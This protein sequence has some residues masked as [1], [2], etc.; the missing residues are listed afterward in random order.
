MEQKNDFEL[1]PGEYTLV[2]VFYKVSRCTPLS[3]KKL[4][5]GEPGDR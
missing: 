3:S 1:L 4:M 5:E 2:A